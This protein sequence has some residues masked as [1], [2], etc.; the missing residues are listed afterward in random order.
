MYKNQ[1]TSEQTYTLD[2]AAHVMS[3]SRADIEGLIRQKRLGFEMSDYG[4]VITN[5]QI[6]SYYLGERPRSLPEYQPVGFRRKPRKRYPKAR[7]QR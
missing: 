6:A 4:P 7:S 5:K 2:E 3:K 1:Y